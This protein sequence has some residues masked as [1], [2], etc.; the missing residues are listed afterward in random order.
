MKPNLDGRLRAAGAV[1]FSLAVVT[2]SVA[3]L[4]LLSVEAIEVGG[5]VWNALMASVEDLRAVRHRESP[6]QISPDQIVVSTLADSGAGSLRQAVADAP[7]GALITFGVTGTLR[8]SSPI[9]IE[10]SLRIEGPQTRPPTVILSGHGHAP[11]LVVES[12]GR[13]AL[14]HLAVVDGVAD[15]AHYLAGGITNR[16]VLTVTDSLIRENGGWDS[17]AGVGNTGRLFAE[18]VRFD[19]NAGRTG[20]ALHNGIEAEAYVVDSWMTGNASEREGGAVHARGTVWITNTRI[21]SNTAQ[22]GGGVY[23]SAVVVDSLISGNHA[24]SSG[25]GASLYGGRLIRTAVVSNTAEY[26]GGGLRVRWGNVL[27]A[28]TTFHGN[29]AARS[30]RDSGSGGAILASGRL[31][32]INVTLAR[33]RAAEGGGIMYRTQAGAVP[34]V[35]INSLFVDN[36]PDN[37]VGSIAGQGGNLQWPENGCGA[38][39]LTGDPLIG[40]LVQRDQTAFVVPD[41]SGAAVNAAQLGPC[42]TGPVA[43][44]DQRGAS[45]PHGAGCDIGAIEAG[46]VHTPTPP[47]V[48]PATATPYPA[49]LVVGVPIWSLERPF[50]CW[51]PDWPTG[52]YVPF[53]NGGKADA[54]PFNVSMEGEPTRR[55]PGLG[56]GESASLFFRGAAGEMVHVEVDADDEVPEDYE[57]NNVYSGSI[58]HPTRPIPCAELTAQALTPSATQRTPTA[59]RTSTVTRPATDTRTPTATDTPTATATPTETPLAKVH[60]PRLHQDRLPGTTPDPDRVSG[61]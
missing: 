10:R 9:R 6:D 2:A 54:G 44:V 7:D 39:V 5:G 60:L 43:A 55:V 19:D 56:A 47:A 33:N 57:D 50:P 51:L 29:S 18:R 4:G 61:R 58:P 49:D 24:R 8:L 20:G 23:G 38:T 41:G 1:T 37:C 53:S 59:T 12:E 52:V 13:V 30:D 21:V 15:P 27:L 14:R 32:G 3:A 35:F 34:P 22:S 46:S 40:D 16:G 11:V 31:R 36:V 28:N 48:P 17:G 26:E 45:R 25:G 42:L